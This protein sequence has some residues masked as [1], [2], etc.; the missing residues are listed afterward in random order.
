M[1]IHRGA[2]EAILTFVTPLSLC[3]GSL[4][5]QSPIDGGK[6]FSVTLFNST[7]NVGQMAPKGYKHKEIKVVINNPDQAE[8]LITGQFRVVTSRG[9]DH[10]ANYYCLSNHFTKN[11]KSKNQICNF[12]LYKPENHA[13]L[14]R[15]E[16]HN[17]TKKNHAYNESRKSGLKNQKI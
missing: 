10:Y 14:K 3:H 4:T 12:S 16:N 13:Y 2:W 15:A 9:I 17:K 11:Q 8:H 7:I 5:F 1:S 6:W